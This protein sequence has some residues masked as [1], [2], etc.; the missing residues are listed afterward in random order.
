MWITTSKQKTQAINPL[1]GYL[2]R[3]ITK[4]TQHLKLHILQSK[5]VNKKFRILT[6]MYII[7][8]FIVTSRHPFTHNLPNSKNFNPNFSFLIK[9]KDNTLHFHISHLWFLLQR[10]SRSARLD[11]WAVSAP[12]ERGALN[13][14][15]RTKQIQ[16]ISK[17]CPTSNSPYRTI[18]ERHVFSTF[19]YSA[20]QVFYPL[21]PANPITEIQ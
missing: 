4:S 21:L 7:R 1:S 16:M 15:E 3:T 18:S 12:T 8:S 9:K 5:F 6:L 13:F 19:S 17:I 10:L 14:P 20:R 2:S 11:P